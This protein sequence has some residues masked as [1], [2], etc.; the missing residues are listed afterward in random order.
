MYSC[1][2]LTPAGRTVLLAMF[3]QL[4]RYYNN[5]KCDHCT[6]S[7]PDTELPPLAEYINIIGVYKTD[8]IAGVVVTVG[9]NQYRPD[10][11]LYH[12]TA[13]HSDNVKPVHSNVVLAN[14]PNNVI[15]L[16]RPI[17][18]SENVHFTRGLKY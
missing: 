14:S 1:Y 10:G 6:H 5:I 15:Y 11:K 12:I 9:D 4:H 8:D 3:N 16:S 13:A 17:K 18:L 2:E 7:F